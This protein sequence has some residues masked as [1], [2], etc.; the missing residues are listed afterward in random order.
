MSAVRT[1]H[2][3]RPAALEQPGTSPV[4]HRTPVEPWAWLVGGAAL[5]FAAPFVGTDLLGL[6]PDLYYLGYFTIAVTWFAVFLAAHRSELRDLWRL[7]LTWS[8]AV[9]ALA[10]VAVAA[11]VFGSAATD[12]PDGWRWWFEIGWRGVVYGCV[13]TLTLFVFPAA[14]AYLVVHGDRR[15]AQRKLGYA[16]L[17]LAFS[18]VVSTSYHLGYPEY[19]GADL[20]SPLVGTVIADSSAILT[21]NPVGA[22]LTHG[23]AH[24]SAVV[25]Q[26]EGGPTHMLPPKVDAGYPD[27]GDSDLAVALA[28]LWVLGL[29]SVLTGLVLRRHAR[30]RGHAAV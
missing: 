19:R 20:R 14:V 8:L 9:G 18:L 24:V 4:S 23:T 6:Q 5:F 13:D 1:L 16:G 11:V 15:G 25:H 17:V 22:F 26:E 12:H 3:H 28:G 21:G 29:A 7:N 10:G 30:A 27:R 2:L